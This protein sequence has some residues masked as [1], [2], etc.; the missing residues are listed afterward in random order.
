M[1]DE[2]TET[3]DPND[4]RIVAEPDRRAQLIQS[5]KNCMNKVL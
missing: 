5:V 2:N 1:I 4:S 3:L